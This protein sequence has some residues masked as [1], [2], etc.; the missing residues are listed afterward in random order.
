[1]GRVSIKRVIVGISGSLGNLA[2]LHAGVAEA[3]QRDVP[4]LA[5]RAWTPTGGEITY[6]KSPSPPL[7]A[8]WHRH[9]L[10]ALRTA[11]V[12]A[13][14]GVPDDVEVETRLVRGDPGAALVR[15]AD[16]LGDLLVIGT[17]RPG[18][19]SRLWRGAVSRYCLAHARCKVLAVP[20][21]DLARELR[22]LR[23]AR[24]VTAQI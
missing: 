1:M 10:T 23:R 22:R 19:F 13:F 20:Q 17:G 9:E 7:V 21:P 16:Q 15:T 4:L 8:E 12:D 18:R 3:R 2:A 24:L 14:G 11:F 5:V 6:R